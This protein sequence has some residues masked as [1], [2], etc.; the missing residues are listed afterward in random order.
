MATTGNTIM[1]FIKHDKSRDQEQQV[2]PCWK[3]TADKQIRREKKSSQ[4]GEDISTNLQKEQ[5]FIR[6]ENLIYVH[7]AD[8]DPQPW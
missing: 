5:A 2:W 4:V 7:G 3:S 1:G 6:L 8:L